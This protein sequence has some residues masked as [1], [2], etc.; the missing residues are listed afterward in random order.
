MDN[1]DPIDNEEFTVHSSMIIIKHL[2][3]RNSKNTIEV[4]FVIILFHQQDILCERYEA[5]IL[6]IFTGCFNWCN[7]QSFSDSMQNT[8][9]FKKVYQGLPPFFTMVASYNQQHHQTEKIYGD[10]TI[11]PFDRAR[12]TSSVNLGLRS[13]FVYYSIFFTYEIRKWCRTICIFPI[14]DYSFFCKRIH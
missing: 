8:N 4:V 10:N 2:N 11:K 12:N 1:K 3:M 5:C 6:V 14:P 7:I 9:T 13:S